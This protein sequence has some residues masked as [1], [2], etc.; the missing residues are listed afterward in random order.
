MEGDELGG[1]RLVGGEDTRCHF[2]AR[3]R[4]AAHPE[5][6]EVHRVDKLRK[7]GRRR[8][9]AKAAEQHGLVV[10]HEAQQLGAVPEAPRLETRRVGRRFRRQNERERLAVKAALVLNL[11]RLHTEACERL[12]RHREAHRSSP[13]DPAVRVRPGDRRSE[14]GREHSDRRQRAEHWMEGT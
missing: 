12:V 11:R 3:R 6:L 2:R 1:R 5:L 8:G 14:P 4:A 7:V 13:H 10:A 9:V